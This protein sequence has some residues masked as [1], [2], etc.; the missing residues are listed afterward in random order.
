VGGEEFVVVLPGADQ[1]Q[2]AA[3]AEALRAA[4]AALIPAGLPVTASFGVAERQPDEDYE[5][6]FKRAD[7]AVYRAK[8]AG[9]N[10]VEM[11]A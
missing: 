7:A 9:R 11:A 10:R 1:A 3:Q 4:V 8:E 2:A 5:D 6:L